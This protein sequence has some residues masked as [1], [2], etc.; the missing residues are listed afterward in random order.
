MSAFQELIEGLPKKLPELK[1]AFY[2]AT[3]GSTNDQALSLGKDG[4]EEGTLVV[5]D[6][7]SKG[8]GRMQRHW[9]SPAG[10]GLYF[11]LLLRPPIQAKEVPLLTIATGLAIGESL[12]V[13]GLSPLI[14]KW[15]NDIIVQGKKVAGTLTELVTTD[16]GVDFV[17]LGIGINVNQEPED[18]SQTIQ[19]IAGSLKMLSKRPWDRAELLMTLIP[20]IFREVGNLI[21][22]GSAHLIQ[23]WNQSSGMVGHQIR[24]RVDK[25]EKTGKVLGLNPQGHLLMQKENGEIEELVAAD[26]TLL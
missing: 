19:N 22:Q 21:T 18:F 12:R 25:E 26:T 16:Q 17:I 3:L 7:Q 20:A 11:S 24:A 10:T 6:H 23:R 15:P 5:A 9:E 8:R 1:S 2:F 13:M 14:I 4:A